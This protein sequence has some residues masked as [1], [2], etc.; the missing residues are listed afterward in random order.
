MSE[1][2]S[3]RVFFALWPDAEASGH[4]AALGHSLAGGGGRAIRPA[5]LHLTLAFVGSV[6]PSQV[7][8]LERIAAA[9]RADAFELS[10]DRLGFWPQRGIL[11]AGCRQT[12]APLRRLGERLGAEL[13]AADFA[14][15]ARSGSAQV[16][17]VTLA[18]R[19]RCASLPRL[20]TPVRWPV[21]EFALVETHLH[22][23]AASY[24]TLASF[25]LAAAD[26]D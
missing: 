14:I 22:P 8:E 19:V 10:L 17:H 7:A 12:P 5:S 16:P 20:E 24:Q 26:L 23:S 3:R 18:R 1:A 4:L 25:P 13:R 2:R 9:V 21:G 15:A 6:T 11:W